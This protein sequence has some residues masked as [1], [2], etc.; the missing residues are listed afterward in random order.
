[1]T[2]DLKRRLAGAD[3]ERCGA[4]VHVGHP[5]S[6]KVSCEALPHDTDQAHI[7]ADVDGNVT[8]QWS[9][10]PLETQYGGNDHDTQ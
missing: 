4:F 9:D 3:E 10:A 8:I 7:A 1:M 6:A 5:G 2:D